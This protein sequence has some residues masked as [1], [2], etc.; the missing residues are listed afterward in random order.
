MLLLDRGAE[1]RRH[2]IFRDLP[3]L[4]KPGDLLVLNDTRVLPVRLY[5]IKSTGARIEFT[6]VENRRDFVEWRCLAKPGRRLEPGLTIPVGAGAAIKVVEKLEDGSW[7]VEI[8]ADDVMEALHGAG[9]APLPPYIKRSMEDPRDE[10][11]ERYQTVYADLPG[12]VAAPTAGLHFTPKML[13]E[14]NKMGHE[15]AKVTLHVGWGSFAPVRE[16]VAEDH[17]VEPEFFVVGPETVEAVMKTKESGGRVVA[18]GTTSV[19][20]LESACGDGHIKP[21]SG[22]TDLYILPGYEF[23]AVDAMITNFHLPR[24]S[25]IMLVAAF[26]GTDTVLEAY[27]EAVDMNYR[28]YSYGDSMLIC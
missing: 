1:K 25:L 17:L 18:V 9:R 26:A 21:T 4:L 24:S 27:R 6:L 20:A 10:D 12:A 15:T 13:E 11:I 3:G 16:D 28:F 2:L 5:G 8:V 14:I 22:T 19:R 23:K 7:I